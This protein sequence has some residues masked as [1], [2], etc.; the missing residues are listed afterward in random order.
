MLPSSASPRRVALLSLLIAV[1]SLPLVLAGPLEVG[2]QIHSQNDL[3]Q[4]P[5]TL[6]KGGS[7]RELWMKVDMLYE[8]PEFCQNTAYPAV[9]RVNP[10][11]AHLGCFLLTHDAP[12]PMRPLPYNTSDDVLNM[13]VD[14]SPA[15]APYFAPE[16]GRTISI[17]LCAK[18][19]GQVCDGSEQSND[20][21]ALMD[22]FVARAQESVASLGLAV[23]FILDGAFTPSGTRNACLKDKWQPWN[24]TF[25]FG[26]DP[27]TAYTDN[28]ATNG[29]SRFQINN[30]NIWG[31]V[32]SFSTQYGKFG[33]AQDPGRTPGNTY[34][35]SYP[36]LIW[37]PADQ[38][39]LSED[40][41]FI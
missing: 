24:A 21:I 5:Q 37:E 19:G 26:S 23:E 17:A 12:A 35:K 34:T 33:L 14:P 27:A 10:A 22:D 16:S 13:I 31:V 18:F 8:P 36:F 6:L 32:P 38:Y 2:Y 11:T 30:M 3:R 25:I 20:F 15:L 1:A 28:N 41:R 29:D 4:W 40:V 7:D 9:G 39:T